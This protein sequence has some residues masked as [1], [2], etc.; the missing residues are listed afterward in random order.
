MFPRGK[1]INQ[2]GKYLF[3]GEKY[4]FSCPISIFLSL[5]YVNGRE[6]YINLP[7]IYADGSQ[8]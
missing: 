5:K 1:Y 2:R 7:V 6:K 4:L 8:I 3:Q